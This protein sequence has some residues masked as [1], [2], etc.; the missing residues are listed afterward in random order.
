MT[1]KLTL[2]QKIGQVMMVGF[3]GLE[4]TDTIQ[5]MICDYHVGSVI[6]FPRN[7]QTRP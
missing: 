7:I 1:T 5:S 3:D 6:T 2:E 4:A